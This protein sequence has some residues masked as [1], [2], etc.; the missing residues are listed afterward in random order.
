MLSV[1]VSVCVYVCMYSALKM[2]PKHKRMG[3]FNENSN[4]ESPLKQVNVGMGY[5]NECAQRAQWE[6]DGGRKVKMLVD[7]DIGDMCLEVKCEA[8]ITC[9]PTV[10]LVLCQT[11]LDVLTK[12][13]YVVANTPSSITIHPVLTGVKGK[14]GYKHPSQSTSVLTSLGRLLL[15]RLHQFSKYRSACV[16]SAW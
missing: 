11:R 1:Y 12:E 8:G 6:Q 15:L 16:K 7:Q 10:A 4:R 2:V 3:F 5:I 9:L 13:N 14:R